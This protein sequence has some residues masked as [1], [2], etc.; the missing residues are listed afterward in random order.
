MLKHTLPD[1][2]SKIT[3]QSIQDGMA[4]T[5]WPGRLDLLTKEQH[6]WLK[7]VYGI[8]EMFVDGAHNPP[9][10]KALR[11]FV[12]QQLKI[13]HLHKV[14]WILASTQGK[15]IM[16]LLNILLRPEDS[17]YTTVFTQPENMPWIHSME[18]SEIKGIAAAA[19][20][21]NCTTHVSLNDALHAVGQADHSDELIVLC[22]SLYLVADLYR[23]H[24]QVS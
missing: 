16:E 14:H 20:T 19:V 3:M 8:D 18:P 4:S 21:G 17:V 12:D 6:P 7:T 9:A 2:G 15:D 13:R 10:A 24:R 23:L 1:P 11:E 5:R 22:G